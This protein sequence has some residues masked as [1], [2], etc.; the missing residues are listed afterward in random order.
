VKLT[1]PGKGTKELD[2][3]PEVDFTNL[4]TCCNRISGCCC[5]EMS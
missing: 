5:E 3:I 2:D 4:V 1:T